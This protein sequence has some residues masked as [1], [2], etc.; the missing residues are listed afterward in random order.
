MDIMPT[1]SSATPAKVTWTVAA[2]I[3][4]ERD[5]VIARLLALAGPPRLRLAW[6]VPEPTARELK[7]LGEAFRPYRSVAAWYCWRAAELYSGAADSALT[8]LR[9]AAADGGF[10]LPLLEDKANYRR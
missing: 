2:R 7:P 10:D 5:L 3:L 8:G 4:A 6:Q 1:P 9:E